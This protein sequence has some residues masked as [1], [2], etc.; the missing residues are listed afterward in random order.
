MN[1]LVVALH[2]FVSVDATITAMNGTVTVAPPAGEFRAAKKG[3]TLGEGSRV[4]TAAASD[5]TLQLTDGSMLKL[6]EKSE[7]QVAVVKTE[8]PRPAMVLFFGRLW[9]KVQKVAGGSASFEVVTGSAVAGVRGTEF[10]TAAGDDGSARVTVTEGSV[11]VD[12]EKKQV[13]VGAGQQTDASASSVDAPK[14]KSDTDWKKWEADKRANLQKNGESI[15]KD[16]KESIDARA[17]EAQKL[18]ERQ[19]ALKEEFPNATDERKEEIKAEV[20]KNAQRLA[21][22][23]VRVTGQFGTFEHWGELASDPAFKFAGSGYIKGELSKLRKVKANFDKMVAEGTD[24]S[25]KS[26]EKMMDDM[27]GGKKTIKDKKGSS[28]DD[29]FKE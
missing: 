10:E 9:S 3:E 22:L 4:R 11:A 26:L 20:R 29:L 25:V 1:T 24:M 15:A 28:K 7:M 18:Y 8:S 2:L 14:P 6:R 23:G 19:K 12:N 5:A 17:A 13:S 16:T 27:S 21:E